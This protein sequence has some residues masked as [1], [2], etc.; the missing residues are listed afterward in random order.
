MNLLDPGNAFDLLVLYA[1][2][3]EEMGEQMEMVMDEL[4]TGQGRRKKD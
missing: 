3:A 2:R 4:Y 1:M